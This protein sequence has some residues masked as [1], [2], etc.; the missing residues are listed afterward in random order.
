MRRRRS[1]RPG[2]GGGGGG[3]GEGG[4]ARIEPERDAVRE[5]G[6]RRTC[7]ACDNGWVIGKILSDA[8]KVYERSDAALGQLV[9]RADA[10]EHEQVGRRNGTSA[11]QHLARLARLPL[12]NDLRDA[13]L[14]IR[15]DVRDAR[16]TA[17]VVQHDLQR[18]A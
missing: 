15:P 17:G 16:R 4:E 3:G 13:L 12:C 6:C 2:K 14:T 8:W 5:Q 18:G 11:E 7:V 10:R 1:K 9:A